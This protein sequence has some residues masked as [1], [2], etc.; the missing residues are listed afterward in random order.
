MATQSPPNAVRH[1]N[2]RRG[3]SLHFYRR[4]AF[5]INNKLNQWNFRKNLFNRL[6]T[7]EPACALSHLNLRVR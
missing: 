1:R 7:K 6:A 5:G 2:A 4:D 3:D